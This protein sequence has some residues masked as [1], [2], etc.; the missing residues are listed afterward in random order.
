[1]RLHRWG[2]A[3]GTVARAGAILLAAAVLM[4]ATGHARAADDER[5]LIL[6]PDQGR[7]VPGDS[8]GG[9]LR[10][11]TGIEVRGDSISIRDVLARA[12][13]AEL[14][15]FEGLSTL[16]YTQRVRIVMT[17]GGKKPRTRVHDRVERVYFRAPDR[18]VRAAVLDSTWEV[19]ADGTPRSL[20]EDEDDV[21]VSV[22]RD[23][24]TRIPY[25]LERL[26]RFRF[27][28]NPPFSITDSTIVYEISFSPA[29]DFDEMPGGRIW[30]LTPGYRIVRE[31]FEM[32]RLPFPWVLKS[33]DLL[34]REWAPVGDWWLEKRIAGR[35]RMGLNFLGLPEETE[36]VVSFDD[37]RLN[38]E[39]DPGLFEG[40]DR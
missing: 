36:F 26:E 25:Y 9:P 7:I 16:A 33:L 21:S 27:G 22:G 17:F 6:R 5:I 15:K 4:A 14:R 19:G 30:L 12:R 28:E 20:K 1:M 11:E 24:L 39:L 32:S 29:S 23:D 3:G 10:L 40:G 37:Y 2:S 8:T 31:E 34:T 18:W 35:A 38:P 13:E